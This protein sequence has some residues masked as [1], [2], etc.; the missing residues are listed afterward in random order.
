MRP[1]GPVSPLSRIAP[2]IVGVVDEKRRRGNVSFLGEFSAGRRRGVCS[3]LVFGGV[4]CLLPGGEPG[5]R[6]RSGGFWTKSAVRRRFSFRTP[7]RPGRFRA[8]RAPP[9]RERG[10][11]S[12]IWHHDTPDNHLVLVCVPGSAFCPRLLYAGLVCPVC[13]VRGTADRAPACKFPALPSMGIRESPAPFRPPRPRDAFAPRSR[14]VPDMSGRRRVC[15]VQGAARC[16]ATA[17]HA[18]ATRQPRPASAP[19]P[20]LGR[21]LRATSCGQARPSAQ[22]GIRMRHGPRRDCRPRNR[23]NKR[24]RRC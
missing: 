3:V 9:G 19:C 11:A 5:R 13:P 16:K 15:R 12:G 18:A 14:P 23:R 20:A 17:P 6:V 8:Y 2:G 24:D 7:G 21:S 22:E 1:R 4:R 10:R